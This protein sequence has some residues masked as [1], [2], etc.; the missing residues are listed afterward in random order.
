MIYVAGPGHGGPALVANTYLE[1]TYSEYYPNVSEDVHGLR[2]LFKQF[3][4]P[5]GIPSHVAP[6]TP[7]LDPRRRRA[8]LLAVAC[9]RRRVRQPGSHRRLR[10]RRRR[11][12]DRAARDQLAFEQ[13][14]QP[15][16]RR[17]GAADPASQ[18]L[19]D[20][21]PDGARAH[22]ARRADAAAQRLRLRAA[23]RRRRSDPRGDAPRDGA[24]ARSHRRA[25]SGDPAA[26]RAATAFASARAGRRSS[27]RRRKDG[28]V[29]AKSTAVPVEGTWRSHQVPLAELAEKRQ[30]LRLLEEWMRSYRPEEL[31]T[32][33]GK[34][35]PELRALAPRGQAPHGR[36]PARQRRHPA[37]QSAAAGF[38]R[39]RRRR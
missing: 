6:E 28:P 12:G 9:V 30:H 38:P 22:S 27:C 26:T 5:G 35:R 16:A 1:G 34:L 36:Q 3:S 7:G 33:E 18:R 4:F 25:D 21:R 20:R 13:V 32:S 31:F 11:G 37:A 15:G 17:R 2:R 8:R 10:H 24:H 19:Q 23:L 14:S 29:R 39:V